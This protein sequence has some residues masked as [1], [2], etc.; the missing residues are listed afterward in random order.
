MKMNDRFFFEWNIQLNVTFFNL[1]YLYGMSKAF[2]DRISSTIPASSRNKA[3]LTRSPVQSV[4]RA[5]SSAQSMSHCPSR[6]L[7]GHRWET[8][9]KVEMSKQA[10]FVKHHHI[11]W[12]FSPS[13]GGL[14]RTLDRGWAAVAARGDSGLVAGMTLSEDSVWSGN[15]V[16]DSGVQAAGAGVSLNPRFVKSSDSFRS[17][18]VSFVSLSVILM[19]PVV[20]VSS[21][22]SAVSKYIKIIRQHNTAMLGYSALSS[23]SRKWNALWDCEWR[24]L[25][26]SH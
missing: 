10:H 23:V 21:M 15:T 26:R 18:D 12:A 9:G 5:S 22:Q 16:T 19:F 11:L 24:L 7:H 8:E 17:E 6:R 1:R 20:F 13:V 14:G 25:C 4:N 3:D 2:L